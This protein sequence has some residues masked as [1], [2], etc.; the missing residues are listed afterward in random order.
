MIDSLIAILFLTLLFLGIPVVTCIVIGWSVDTTC[1]KHILVVTIMFPVAALVYLSRSKKAM[2]YITTLSDR[3]H[4]YINRDEHGMTQA[5]YDE[6]A[7]EQQRIDAL[8]NSVCDMQPECDDPEHNDEPGVE[9]HI[10]RTSMTNMYNE[11]MQGYECTCTC[12]EQWVAGTVA[13]CTDTAYM[14]PVV[15]YR[16]NLAMA[17]AT[18]HI[19]AIERM[20]KAEAKCQADCM[21]KGNACERC[22]EISWPSD[23]DELL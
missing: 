18:T 19:A 1:I 21:L 12:G 6:C 2:C 20:P 16:R 3:L 5:D 9:H 22:P 15:R 11:P 4:Q 7:R 10:T 13:Y 8:N 14:C 17:M 23:Y